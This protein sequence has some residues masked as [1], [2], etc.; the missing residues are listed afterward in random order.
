MLTEPTTGATSTQSCL[1]SLPAKNQS[2]RVPNQTPE[3]G[4]KR[5]CQLPGNPELGILC[6]A[7]GG[8]ASRILGKAET[9]RG[10]GT[11]LGGGRSPPAGKGVRPESPGP[12]SEQTPLLPGRRGPAPWSCQEP[13]RISPGGEGTPGR[14]LLTLRVPSP[15]RGPLWPWGSGLDRAVEIHSLQ[16]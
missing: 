6:W 9:R 2:E 5:P 16:S 3:T 11:T 14:A 4:R 8:A 13:P 10:G 12:G 1:P 7:P 15:P